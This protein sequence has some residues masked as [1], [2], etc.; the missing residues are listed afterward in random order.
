MRLPPSPRNFGHSRQLYFFDITRKRKRSKNADF[1]DPP[2]RANCMRAARAHNNLSGKTN[3]RG[4]SDLIA[5]RKV[6]TMIL[7]NFRRS[8]GKRTQ[9]AQSGLLKIHPLRSSLQK[10][11]EQRSRLTSNISRYELR[12][13]QTSF[14]SVIIMT[15][16]FAQPTLADSCKSRN[17]KACL[18]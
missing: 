5:S 6:S 4:H 14:L 12:S 11:A 16:S 15:M 10:F 2:D 7:T 8:P 3:A 13:S 1:T 9:S 17:T 18:R